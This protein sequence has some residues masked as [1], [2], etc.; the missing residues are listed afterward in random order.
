MGAIFCTPGSRGIHIA[1]TGGTIIST[2]A[3]LLDIVTLSLFLHFLW[4]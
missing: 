4:G 2:P 3:Q 1:A